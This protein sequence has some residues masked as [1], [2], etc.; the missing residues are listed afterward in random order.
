VTPSIT[1]DAIN[2][3]L[4]NLILAML[5]Q[6]TASNIIIG[7]VN[8][9][10]SP[11]GDFV[12]FWPLRRPRLGTNFDQDEIALF[13]GSISGTILTVTTV[14]G[15][16]IVAGAPM[17]GGGVAANIIIVA[18]LSGTPGGIGQYAVSVNQQVSSAT[19]LTGQTSILQPTECVY[20][21]DVHGPNSADNAQVISTLFRDEFSVDQLE[22]TGLSPFFADDPRQMPFT[23]AAN[24]YE[25]RWV[26]EAHFQ[27]DPV[28]TIAQ[29]FATALTIDLYDVDHLPEVNTLTTDLTQPGNEVVVPLIL[30]GV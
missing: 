23:T 20:Q 26:I 6:L 28:L 13:V 27:I 9:V 22:A 5:P 3:A 18:Q 7:Q 14:V 11:E 16:E 1:E 25:N 24:Q 21:I 17:F 30:S 4:G 29:Q 15:G 19:F 8:R 12:V 2:T 10:A